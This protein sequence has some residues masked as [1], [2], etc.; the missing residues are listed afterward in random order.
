[1]PADAIMAVRLPVRPSRRLPLSPRRVRRPSLVA[2]TLL[3]ML[4]AC[5]GGATPGPSSGARPPGAVPPPAESRRVAAHEFGGA[6]TG[7]EVDARESFYDVTGATAA[8]LRAGMLRRGLTAASGRPVFGRH[9]WRVRWT[10]RTA[11]TIGG[12]ELRDIR[13]QLTLET[14][15]PRWR[16][17]GDAPPALVA[18]WEEFVGA[19]DTH[20]RGHRGLSLE[21]GREAARALRSHASGT[22]A[23][24]GRQA[25]AA[26]QRVVETY[27]DRNRAYDD[28]TRHGAT[29]GA[30]WPPARGVRLPPP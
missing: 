21:A 20:E 22:C 18:E 29:Q 6:P 14:I 5:A 4:A 26:A 17:P 16:P 8:A 2:T 25:S 11:P 12:C 1:M 30:V 23:G 3:P 28:S 19:L 15:M 27:R 7:V 13:V 10:Y 9:D 24:L